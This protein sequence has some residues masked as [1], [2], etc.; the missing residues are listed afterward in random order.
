MRNRLIF[1]GILVLS[2]L[3]NLTSLNAVAATEEEKDILELYKLAKAKDPIVGRS[4]ARFEAAEAD[5]DI[6][7]S[8]LLPRINASAAER[9]FWHT[10]ENYNS[11][12]DMNGTYEG[13]NY[14]FT[15][16]QPLFNLPS[17]LQLSASN[18]GVKGADAGLKAAQQDLMVRLMN[19][20]VALLKAQ[21]DEKLYRDELGRVGKILQQAEAFLKAGTGDIIAVYEAK[22]RLDSASADLIKTQAQLSTAEQALASL[23]GITVKKIKGFPRTEPRGPQPADISWWLD[24]MQQNSQTI[25]QATE[26]LKQASKYSSANLAGHLPTIQLSGGYT[27]DKGSTFLPKVE[28]K[29]WY[30]GVNISLPIYSGGETVARTRRAVAGESERRSMLDEAQDQNTKRLK[31]SFLNLQYNVSLNEAYRRKHESAELQL[32]AT[33]KGRSIGTRTAI[34]LLNAEQSYAVSRRDLIHS[35]YDNLLRNIELK[36][37]AGILVEEDMEKLNSL[38]IPPPAKP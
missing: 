23:T 10:V 32:K 29:Q 11:S 31:D 22:A 24:T 13:Y 16:Q 19:A 9:K 35:L 21:A 14:S 38:L 7:L 26:E 1:L 30:V 4:K 6:S 3:L 28:T 33:Q 25:R 8:A 27:V 37:N 36:A 2:F 15:G 18:Y 34:D 5:Y 20:Y 12:G 17:Y